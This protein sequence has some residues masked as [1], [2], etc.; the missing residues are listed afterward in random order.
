M[1][2]FLVRAYKYVFSDED[3]FPCI[4]LGRINSIC[5]FINEWITKADLE[6]SQCAHEYVHFTA[7]ISLMSIYKITEYKS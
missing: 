1:N 7:N 5:D 6:Y 4:F 3:I 2:R